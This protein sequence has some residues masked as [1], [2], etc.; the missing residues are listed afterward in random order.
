MQKIWDLYIDKKLSGNLLIRRAYSSL[1]QKHFKWI[2]DPKGM[3]IQQWVD[4]CCEQL[5]AEGYDLNET[6]LEMVESKFIKYDIGYQIPEQYE[7]LVESKNM[8]AER[9][10]EMTSWGAS[11][12]LLEEMKK[13]M[14]AVD[15]G[16]KALLR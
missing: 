10:E 6:P 7:Q 3:T 1:Y 5:Q 15:S 14:D 2:V 13:S 4:T 9:F 8:F 11:E 16:I 12:E